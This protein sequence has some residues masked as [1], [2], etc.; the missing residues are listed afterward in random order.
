M[1]TYDTIVKYIE[2]EGN[3]RIMLEVRKCNYQH[4]R[5][6]HALLDVCSKS[7]TAAE[8]KFQ[9]VINFIDAVSKD[10][11]SE[12]ARVATV[13]SIYKNTVSDYVRLMKVHQGVLTISVKEDRFERIHLEKD[14]LKQILVGLGQYASIINKNRNNALSISSTS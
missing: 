6:T 12:T 11:D 10:K 1:I 7:I 14:R 8:K 2:W 5:L 13:L 3:M 4:V 9:K